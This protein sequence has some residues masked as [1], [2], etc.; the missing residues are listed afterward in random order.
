M[1]QPLGGDR[2][3]VHARTNPDRFQSFQDGNAG[4]V[5]VIVVTGHKIS[6]LSLSFKQ[7][8]RSIL[9]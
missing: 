6:C 4:G 9:A 2:T 1:V 8:I 3:Y 7:N 5:I